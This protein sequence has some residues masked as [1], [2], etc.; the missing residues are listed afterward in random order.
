M[1]KSKSRKR[2]KKQPAKQIDTLVA[3][4]YSL[5]ENGKELGE[6]SLDDFASK[7]KELLK[8]RF[9]SYGKPREQY[10]RFSNLGKNPL[11]LWYDINGT[12]PTEPSSPSDLLKFLY[13]D[14]I[15]LLVLF[16]A[17]QAGHTVG[18][19]QK[20]VELDGVRGSIDATIDGEL[21]DVK[22]TSKHAFRKFESEE[23]L[24]SDDPFGYVAQ[25]S[26]YAQATGRDQGYFLA[27]GKEDGRLQLLRCKADDVRPLI[28][29]LKDILDK[30][31]PPFKCS[32][33]RAF[34][35]NGNRVLGYPCTY[36]KHKEICWQDSNNGT[37]LQS[38][39]Y[40]DSVKHFTNVAREP[41]VE[42]VN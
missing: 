39:Q 5:F 34:G 38:Y 16:L 10:L 13:G 17:E 22:S 32:N 31:D 33:D 1:S 3:D 11:Q 25:I 2:S 28:K 36:C 7:L 23:S 27:V 35:E 20:A 4:I 12:H 8:S 41:R 30:P 19:Q 9:S 18:D 14:L 42:K 6:S 21:V 24:R 15:E 37:G 29:D 40:S 26:G